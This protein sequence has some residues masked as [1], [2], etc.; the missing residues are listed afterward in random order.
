M[1]QGAL[2]GVKNLRVTDPTMT[3]LNVK[4][5]P[6]DGAV[7]QY[8]IFFVPAAGGTELMVGLV[9]SQ[10]FPIMKKCLSHLSRVSTLSQWDDPV[11]FISHHLCKQEQVPGSQT[12]IVLRNLQPDTPYTVSVVPVY[13]ATEG[14]RQSENGRTRTSNADRNAAWTSPVYYRWYLSVSLQCPSEASETSVSTMPPSPRSPPRGKRR[15]ETC[16]ATKWS[17]CPPAVEPSSWYKSL[18]H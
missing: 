9:F 18:F 7:R 11:C 6:A 2:G 14:R 8:K 13:P 5:E 10:T 3:S 17:T 16:R 1:L 15:T 12:T 4:W